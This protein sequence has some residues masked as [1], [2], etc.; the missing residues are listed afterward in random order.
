[1][2]SKRIAQCPGYGAA[3]L[4]L[5]ACLATSPA[6]GQPLKAL[7]STSSFQIPA[8]SLPTA[9][10][11]YTEQ[12]GVHVTSS[13]SLV[14]NKSSRAIVGQYDART[15]LTKLLE[16]TSLGFEPIDDSSVVILPARVTLSPRADEKRALS[17]RDGD[18][19]SGNEVVV[20]GSH[21]RGKSGN[22]SQVYSFDRSDI[23][24]TGVGSIQDFMRMIPQN[25]AGG[26]SEAS[27]ALRS[28]RNSGQDNIGD[29]AGVNLRGLGNEATLVLINGQRMAPSGVGAFHDVST[30]PLNAIERIDVLP[31]GM[32]GIYGADAI[33]GVVNIILRES[34]HGAETEVRYGDVADGTAH[35]MSLSQIIGGTWGTGS[36]VLSGDYRERSQ[37]LARDRAFAVDLWSGHND[38]LPKEE[39]LSALVRG[40]QN[41]SPSIQVSVDA[42]ASNR[43][44]VTRQYNRWAGAQQIS[45]ADTELLGGTAKIDWTAT[46]GWNVALAYTHSQTQNAQPTITFWGPQMFRTGFSTEL[47]VSAIDLKANGPAFRLPAGLAEL[48]VGGERR[49]ESMR[50]RRRPNLTTAAN[51]SSNHRSVDAA[52]AEL[53]LPLLNADDS[54]K[55]M[56]LTMNVAL[57][58]EDF[59]DVGETDNF[60]LGATWSPLAS[61]AFNTTWGTSF[62]A[63]Y[64]WQFDTSG[65]QGIVTYA[66]DPASAS[67]QTS[68]A[69]AYLGPHPTLGPE[70]AETWTAGISLGSSSPGRVQVSAVYFNV[71]YKNR[72]AAPVPAPTVFSDTQ[73]LALISMPPDPE[74]MEWIR[75]API[76]SNLHDIEIMNVEATLDARTHSR[77]SARVSGIDFIATCTTQTPVG[78]IAIGF[79]SN[80]FTRFDTRMNRSAPVLDVLDTLSN[81]VDFRGR[82]QVTWSHVGWS[83]LA[84]LNYVDDYVDNQRTQPRKIASWTTIDLGAAYSFE[85]AGGWF[86]G[87]SVRANVINAAN[88]SPPRVRDLMG[89]YGDPG[90]D[91]ASANPLGRFVSFQ[92]SK[93]W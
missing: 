52:Y 58:V 4:L 90:Y 19:S 87:L 64:L 13:S 66:P 2:K 48:A 11:R 7:N 85:N 9:L 15:A 37:L 42:Y 68:L 53:H 41:L 60:K 61:V 5:Y 84:A 18:A 29:G 25:L 62:R 14:E 34:I 35:E 91:P 56:V 81:P 33:G 17:T 54:I 67:G 55:R 22:G 32:S 10:L 39:R 88:K 82:G 70:K 63:P 20:T 36:L 23:A 69:A 76:F 8:Q 71:D 43:D 31:D 47:G 50:L 92:I 28:F 83:V 80:Y 3:L 65:S 57:R 45:S 24:A 1:M 86:R 78:L 21:I 72:I 40:H 27:S 30:L 49:Y 73:L 12:S 6:F 59:S 74:V 77:S 89:S 44:T 38:L 93:S 46:N 51:E 79:N 75:S 26:R 16:G